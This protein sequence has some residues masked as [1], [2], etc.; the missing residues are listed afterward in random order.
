MATAI[1]LGLVLVNLVMC[2]CIEPSYVP[3]VSAIFK[4]A[5]SAWNAIDGNLGTMAHSVCNSNGN[6][7]WLKLWLRYPTWIDHF[8]IYPTHR[9]SYLHY[10]FDGA[11]IYTEDLISG[12]EILCGTLTLDDA[13]F[14]GKNI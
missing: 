1:T 10:R 5:D 11:R 4:D 14:I 7:I 13:F 8:I 6:E 9:G 3:F 2:L 12:Q